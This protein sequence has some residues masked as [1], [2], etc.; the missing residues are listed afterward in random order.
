MIGSSATRLF[1]PGNRGSNGRLVGPG[2]S[3]P[4]RFDESSISLQPQLTGFRLERRLVG[5]QSQLVLHECAKRLGNE[6]QL[7]LK[8]LIR[9]AQLVQPDA[10]SLVELVGTAPLVPCA[11]SIGKDRSLR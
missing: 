8:P 11:E 5:D 3:P 2:Q 7:V 4:N 9:P 6:V 1:P 10:E